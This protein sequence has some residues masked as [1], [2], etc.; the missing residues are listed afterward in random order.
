MDALKGGIIR[1]YY[2]ETVIEGED[3][4]TNPET[5]ETTTQPRVDYAYNGVDVRAPVTKGALVDAILRA[6]TSEH[7]GYSQADVEAI[8][9][10]KIAKDEGS[11]A[12]FTEFNNFA[13][14][15]KAEASR[16]LED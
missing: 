1:C 10:H 11:A 3:V 12:E 6:G 5:N 8:F 13:E 7:A 16:I 2:N 4:I 15:C 14:W 9:R